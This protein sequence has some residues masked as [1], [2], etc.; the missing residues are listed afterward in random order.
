MTIK[1]YNFPQSTCSQKV[2]LVLWEKGI[3]FVDRP[4]DSTKREHLSDWYLKLNPHGVVPTLIHN[5]DVIIDSSVIIEYLDEVF[6]DTA[7][8]PS[9]AVERAKMRK[10]LRYFEEVPTPAVRVPSFNQYLSKRF[11]KMTEEQF[12]AFTD[13]HPIRRQFYKKMTKEAGFDSK[14]TD[15]AMDRMQQTITFMEQGIEKSGGPWLM[16][17]LLSLADYCVLPVIDRMNDLGHSML[18]VDSPRVSAW[19]AALTQRDAYAKTYYQR[20]R[21][22]E[23]YDGIDL[24]GEPNPASIST[25]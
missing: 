9:D 5:D 1:L 8:T 13:N 17:E 3:E 2:R 22:T 16:G 14:E 4:V 6:P 18:W 21:L 12:K 19:Y 11:D 20:T 23:I 25:D 10:W 7:L 24:G 15:A